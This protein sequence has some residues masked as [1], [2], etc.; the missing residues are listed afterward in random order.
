MVRS[1]VTPSPFRSNIFPLEFPPD[2]V[3]PY[4]L[5]EI[6][7]LPQTPKLR[8]QIRGELR[9]ALLRR[10]VAMQHIDG[11]FAYLV[12]DGGPADPVQYTGDGAVQY[13]ITP[14]AD[15]RVIALGSLNGTGGAGETDLAV[16]L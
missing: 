15:R 10:P 1:D 6:T 11:R 14:T 12:V 5:W 4:R 9:W 8:E 16:V 2:A 3:L 13:T 7:P